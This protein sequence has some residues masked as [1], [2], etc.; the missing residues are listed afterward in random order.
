MLI[1]NWRVLVLATLLVSGVAASAVTFFADNFDADSSA[2]YT[3]SKDPDAVAVFAYDYSAL[4]IPAAPS[5]VGGTTRGLR[6]EANNGDTTGLAAAISLSP[7]GVSVSGDYAL[8]FDLWLNSNGPFPQGG[9]GS[10]QFATAGVG[11]AG[12][13]LHKGGAGDGTWAAVDGEGGSGLDYR[14][15]L[16]GTAQDP[17]S[18]IYAAAPGTPNANNADNAY[19][20]DAFTGQTAPQFQQN[21][22]AQQSGAVKNGSIGFAWRK[23]ELTKV[24]TEV[25]WSIDG[26]RIVTTLGA[27]ISGDNVF[28]GYWDPFT[29]VS[30]NPLLTFGLIDNLRVE[31]I[32]EPGATGLALVGAATLLQLRRRRSSVSVACASV[33]ANRPATR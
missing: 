1:R 26:L 11:T 33:R 27:L 7:I 17:A 25:T 10:T 6:L 15:F 23:V 14:F 29:S 28:I 2:L 5:S 21:A 19:Y 16:N 32:P 22:F 24:G 31:T 3:V 18:G 8:R 9:G 13:T 4:G 20:A 30:D 12:N